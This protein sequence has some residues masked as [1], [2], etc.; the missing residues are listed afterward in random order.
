VFKENVHAGLPVDDVGICWAGAH[1][2]RP[3][4]GT[5][6]M[7][8]IVIQHSSVDITMLGFCCA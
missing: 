2:K 6:I 1:P 7:K 5:M 4:T 3:V 8:I